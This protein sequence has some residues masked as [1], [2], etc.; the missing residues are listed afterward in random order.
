MYMKINRKSIFIGLLAVFTLTATLALFIPWNKAG[1]TK[2][3]AANPELLPDPA[4]VMAHSKGILLPDSKITVVLSSPRENLASERLNPFKFQPALEGSV[5]WSEDGSRADFTPAKILEPGR[6]Y[7]VEFDFEKIGEKENGRFTFEIRIESPMPVYE[8]AV[9]RVLPDGNLV[10]EGRITGDSYSSTSMIEKSLSASLGKKKL[11]VAWSHESNTHS[12]TVGSI[13]RSAKKETLLVEWQ[14]GSGKTKVKGS[15]Q[16]EIPAAGSFELLNAVSSQSGQG[17]S[18]DLFF[19]ENLKPAQDYRGLIRV[20]GVSNLRF[21]AHGGTLSL[22]PE[23]RWPETILLTVDRGVESASSKTIIVPVNTSISFD[24]SLPELRFPAG[25]VIVPTSQ[26]SSVVLETR[27]LAGIYVEALRVYGDNML[28]F[29]QENN[30]SGSYE[31]KR[32]GDIVWSSHIDLEWNDSMKNRWLAH[33]LDLSPLLAS[34]PDGLIQLKV[35]F[36]HDDIRYICPN[37]HPESGQWTFPAN[38]AS[39]DYGSDF[40]WDTPDWYDWRD[41]SRYENDPCTPY[42]YMP[43]YGKDRVAIRNVLISDIAIMAKEDVDSVWHIAVS[44]LKTAQNLAGAEVSI[45]SFSQK[46]IAAGKTGPQGMVSIKTG[47]SSLKPAFIIVKKSGAGAGSGKDTGFLKLDTGLKLAD[48]H[49]EVG[50]QKADSGI[51]GFIY[52]ERG[53]WRPGDDIHLSFILFDREKKIPQGYPLSFELQNPMGQTS[54]QAVYTESENGFYY[55]KTSTDASAM[56]GTWTARVKVGGQVFTKALKIETIMPNRL[57]I[58]LDWGSLPYLSKDNSRLTLSA[59]WLHGATAPNLAADVNL[60]LSES[61]NPFSEWKDFVFN[62]PLAF[63][64]SGKTLLFEGSLDRNSRANF[65]LEPDI[66]TRFP[67]P[68]TASL[69]SRVF[70]KSGMFSTEAFQVQ[71]HPFR[72]YVGIKEPASIS[73]YGSLETGREHDFDLILADMDGKPVSSGDLKVSLYKL[74]WR[75]WWETGGDTLARYAR[76]IERKFVRSEDIKVRNGRAVFKLKLG[77]DDWGPWLVRVE[78]TGSGSSHATGMM[79]Y[80]GWGSPQ[81]ESGDSAAMLNLGTDKEKYNTGENIT[82]NFPSNRGGRAFITVERAGKILEQRWVNGADSQASFSFRA[83]AEM[84]PNVYVHVSF[85]QPHLQTANDLPIRLYGIIPVMVENPATRLSPL[86]TAADVIAPNSVSSVQVSEKNGKAMTY[87]LA[88]VDEGLLG[89]TR[90]VTKDPWDSF[91]TK[92]ASSLESWDIYRDVANAYSGQLQTHLSIGGSDAVDDGAGKKPGRFPPVV[93]YFGPYTLAAG[94]T[95]THEFELGA[96]VGA[97]RM[98]IVAGSTDGAYGTMEKEVQVKS[99]LMP[100]ITAPRVIGPRESLVLPVTVFGFMGENARGSVKIDVEGPATITGSREKTLLWAVEGEENTSFEILT[101]DNTGELK[102]TVEATGPGGRKASQSIVLPVRSSSVNIGRVESK[103]LPASAKSTIAVD[104]PGISGTNEAW[105]ELSHL[106][107]IDLSWQM[108]MLIKYPHG[109]AEQITSRLFPQL[110]LPDAVKL[111][112]EEL[113]EIRTNLRDGIEKLWQFQTV[114]GGFAFWPGLSDENS[115]LSAYMVHFFVMARRSGYSVNAIQLERAIAWLAERA[116]S[117]SPSTDYSKAEQ[118]YR[119]YVLALAGKP[120]IAGLNRLSQYE[121]LQPAARFQLAAA[122][123]LSGM[124]EKASSLIAMSSLDIASY[125]GISAVYGSVLRDSAI[126]LDALNTLGDYTRGAAL[127][128]R[129]ADS[130]SKGIYWST[131]ETAWALMACLPYMKTASGASST[132]LY[133][134]SGGGGQIQLEGALARVPIDVDAG[135]LL[136]NIEN[137]GRQPVY[138]RLVTS[139]T[140]LP[141]GESVQNSGIRLNATYLDSENRIVDPDLPALGEDMSV[142][143][144]VRNTGL[145]R[146]ENIALVFRAPSGWEIS[147]MRLAEQGELISFPESSPFD[148]QDIRDDRV[149]TYFSLAYGEEKAFRIYF[150]KTYDGAFFLPA[151]TAEAMYNNA[152]F[153]TIPGRR[154]QRPGSSSPGSAP[155]NLRNMAP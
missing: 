53:V 128:T 21:E 7:R 64:P 68:L 82:V 69:V 142:I 1:T 33:S 35:S 54:R 59:A 30:L 58:N 117:W 71:Y 131:Q 61:R 100:F 2:A 90:H 105:L 51:K 88:I 150:N 113:A 124:K 73:R 72:R 50:G 107:P 89:I 29:L 14:S 32:V 122:Y 26:G 13:P 94:K 118:A 65:R 3:L 108:S 40:W 43:A 23:E 92:E 10:L 18:I 49:F 146:L 9:L 79:F 126:V 133:D 148:Y 106:P 25:G 31:L 85:I 120:D 99:E 70:E 4:L 55:I 103:L 127:Y 24:W 5:R 66:E 80:S 60:Y 36:G 42:Y 8:K 22:Y 145:E 52:G 37:L 144:S 91:Y 48:S 121:P 83:T 101:G 27:N 56:T 154:L 11:P 44:D 132:V 6:E 62:D 75:W 19:S 102:I 67:G 134:Y 39:W 104:L 76:D 15:D 20:E 46:L 17:G 38:T 93:K 87:T 77:S 97:V 119:L 143:I 28:Q 81:G 135:R 123:G 45:Y 110:F 41:R 16:F 112:A 12:Y 57:K 151:I 147:N 84:A 95:A 141:G 125:A 109:C 96:Y 149:M 116:S 115:W 138:A 130:L 139:G 47:D 34:H 152:V 78:D 137:R 111:T 153:A 140:P 74:E 98:M 155:S 114:R 86:I 129:I 63:Q 136:I